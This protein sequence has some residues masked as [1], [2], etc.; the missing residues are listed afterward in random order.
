[1]QRL[2]LLTARKISKALFVAVVLTAATGCTLFERSPDAGEQLAARAS[3]Q[4][5]FFAS[6]DEVW[7]A[8]H[9]ALKYTIATENPDTGVIETEFIK[10]V[11][12][13]VAPG[14]KRQVSAGA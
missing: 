14:H 2:T 5:I 11:D 8:I 6:Y 7:R 9:T 12:G 13:W 3:R 10:G 1:M 4:R